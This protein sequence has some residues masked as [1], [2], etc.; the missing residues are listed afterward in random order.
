MSGAAKRFHHVGLTT[1][2]EQPKEDYVAPSKCWVTDPRDHFMRIEYLRYAE[3]S[4]VSKEFQASPH[5]A[6]AVDELEPHLE[7]KQIILPPFDVGEPAFATVA[8][9]L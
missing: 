3:D 5:I 2:E 6:Y 9:T 8:F 4:P 1:L 7:G